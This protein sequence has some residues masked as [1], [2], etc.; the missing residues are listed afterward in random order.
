MVFQSMSF[1][2]WGPQL[3]TGRT[4]GFRGSIGSMELVDLRTFGSFFIDFLWR[5]S[6]IIWPKPSHGWTSWGAERH[7][8]FR[9]IARWEGSSSFLLCGIAT[10]RIQ[11]LQS[12]PTKSSV[13]RVGNDEGDTSDRYVVMIRHVES[14]RCQKMVYNY[15]MAIFPCLVLWVSVLRTVSTWHQMW[16][17]TTVTC[18]YIHVSLD[19]VSWFNWNERCYGSK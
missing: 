13:K 10:W 11:R 17:F 4:R 19:H 14:W 1:Q 12:W 5:I 6:R 3:V 8:E 2:N 15:N 7:Q 18:E 16:F 9:M